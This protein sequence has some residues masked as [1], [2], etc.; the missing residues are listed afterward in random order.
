[1]QQRIG[2]ILLEKSIINQTQLDKALSIQARTGSHLGQILV[3]EGMIHHH[4]VDRIMAGQ[5]DLEFFE[6]AKGEYEVDQNKITSE[7]EC[8]EQLFIPLKPDFIAISDPSPELIQVLK[9]KFGAK[10]KIMVTPKDQLLQFFHVHL[11]PELSL[12]SVY[13]L[14]NSYPEFSAGKVFISSQLYSVYILF[15]LGFFWL[16]WDLNSFF[17]TFNVLITLFLLFSFAFKFH[18][19]WMGTHPGV[20]SKIS[21]QEVSALD[22]KDLPLYSILIPMY[23]EPD[24]LPIIVDSIRKLDYPKE[25]LDVKLV[26]EADDELTINAAKAMNLE[27]IFEIIVT[28]HS[29][30]KTKPKACNYALNFIRGEYVTIYDAEDKPEIDQL[31]KALITFQKSEPN[32]AVVQARLNYYNPSENWITKMFTMEYSLWFDFYLPALERLNVPIPLGGTS[33]H[34]KTSILRSVGGW[35]PFNVTEDADLGI[36]YYQRNYLVRVVNS[37]TFEEANTR[38]GNWIRQRSRW[39][40]GYMQT[41]LVHMRKPFHL[42]QTL[43]FKGFFSFQFFIGGTFLT[44][45]LTPLLYGVFILWL[46][47]HTMMF[48]EFFPPLIMYLSNINLLAGNAFF[49]YCLMVGVYKRRYYNLIMTATTAPM[50]WIMLSIASYK[51]LW[52]LFFNPFYWE[53]T[54]HGLSKVTQQVKEDIINAST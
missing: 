3:A 23:K 4:E 34:F 1:M 54:Q 11:G 35:D 22:D 46:F 53:K 17:V 16:Y 10:I 30:P 43:G 44:A 14:A 32:T 31:K 36:R 37:T 13:S 21:N 40:K 7:V 8:I 19:L 39:I 45:M 48:D 28:P 26:L 25:K 18:L 20:D 15:S 41:Y 9:E 51:A 27:E 47:S 42:Y 29:M 5:L 24:V 6:I 49:V 50:Y 12:Q 52:Q 38:Y 2:D 33:N